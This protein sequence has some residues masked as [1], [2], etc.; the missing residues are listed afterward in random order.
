MAVALLTTLYGAMISN[1][2]ALPVADKLA[3]KAQLEYVIRT[4]VIEGTLHIHQPGHHDRVLE[5]LSAR[6]SARGAGMSATAPVG[7]YRG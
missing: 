5:R 6:K 1:L 3:S 7:R 4:L 2:V